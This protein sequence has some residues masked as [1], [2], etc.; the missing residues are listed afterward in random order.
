MPRADA[1]ENRSPEP[2]GHAPSAVEPP[3]TSALRE[4]GIHLVGKVPWGG[5]IC[6]FYE[7]R[8][9]LLDTCSA[10]FAAGMQRNE[11]C[12]W[13]VSSPVTE[14]DAADALRR[15]VPDVDQAL[16]AGKLEIL[17][18]AE[19]YLKGDQF[20]LDS[21]TRGWNEKLESALARGY[22][23]MR[24]SGNAFWA[25][26]AHWK[27]FNQ[28]EL[29]VDESFAGARILALCTYSLPASRAAEILDVARAHNFA[30][31]RRN[32]Q[33]EF[34][35]TP[36]LR[37]AR[38]GFGRLHG[39]PDILSKPFPGRHKLTPR[40]R[41]ALSQIVRGPTNKEA[42]RCLGLSPR[43]VEYHRANIIRKLNAKNTADLVRKVL[44]G[45]TRR[46]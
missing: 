2:S 28:Y 37:D 26:T 36:E 46:S 30:L 19:W 33:W 40:E 17:R 16:A 23:G 14:E 4:T 42:A 13:A 7:T 32:G 39:A 22:D 25:Q 27:D 31:A 43:T 41:A 5:H 11:F 6:V 3:S 35:Q 1:N 38:Q 15:V 34:L 44:E 8:Q 10:Y 18:G 21:I 12:V 45:T 20:D 24:I 29:E 9:D